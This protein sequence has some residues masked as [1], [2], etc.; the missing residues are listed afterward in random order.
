[1]TPK[2]FSPVSQEAVEA[3][4]WMQKQCIKAYLT[5]ASSLK[6]GMTEVNIV[7]AIRAELK[8]SGV[9]DYWYNIPIMVLI[10]VDRFKQMAV[11]DYE[12]KS[13][14]DTVALQ[15][16]LPFFV[17]IHPRHD[18][19][20]WG[21]LAAT[22]VF[23]PRD[24]EKAVEFLKSMQQI[25]QA[26]IARL[27]PSMKCSDVAAW[28]NNRF[29][30]DNVNLVDVRGNFG[31]SMESGEK[32]TSERNFLD[33]NIHVPIGGKIFGIEPGGFRPTAGNVNSVLVARFET[34]VH[35]PQ[36]GAGSVRMLGDTTTL[37]VVFN[38]R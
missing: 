10:G 35:I 14:S 23:R 7:K 22:G 36:E 30:Q 38:N 27:A 6:A 18:S 17:D 15:E 9:K 29:N 2:E 8:I 26:G 5:V 11:D 12:K 16:S 37:S 33:P 34:C 19:G 25:Q 3:T 24:D 4:A 31:H 1:M 32:S 28:F 13:P 20:R 21:D